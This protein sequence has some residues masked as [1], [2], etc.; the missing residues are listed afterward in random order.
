MSHVRF[1]NPVVMFNG[2]Y[3]EGDTAVA[4]EVRQIF[5]KT[6]AFAY[7]V[8]LDDIPLLLVNTGKEVLYAKDFKHL[9]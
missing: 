3:E 4:I 5:H 1:K 6:N 8:G 2:D 7:C 9:I